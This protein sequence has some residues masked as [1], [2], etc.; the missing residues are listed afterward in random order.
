V[1]LV[2]ATIAFLV[3]PYGPHDCPGTTDCHAWG[4]GPRMLTL[5]VTGVVV[6]ALLAAAALTSVKDR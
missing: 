1:A 5:L 3:V 4:A 6:I 2:G